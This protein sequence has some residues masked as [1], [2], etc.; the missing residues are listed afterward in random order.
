ML[1]FTYVQERYMPK[2]KKKKNHSETPKI[3]GWKKDITKKKAKVAIVIWNQVDFNEKKLFLNYY[4]MTKGKLY[5][6]NTV[7]WICRYII[8]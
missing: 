1:D 4:K 7:F 3:S 5:L 6:E 2:K 8:P